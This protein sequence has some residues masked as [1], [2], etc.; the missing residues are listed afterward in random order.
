MY[1]DRFIEFAALA[2]MAVAIVIIVY[3]KM[4]F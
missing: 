3:A 1:R 2:A 4:L